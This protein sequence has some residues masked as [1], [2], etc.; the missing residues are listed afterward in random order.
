MAP[1]WLRAAMCQEPPTTF[2]EHRY[3]MFLGC[4]RND[5]GM[6]TLSAFVI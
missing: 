3:S 6:V 4:N 1:R 2:Q 5:V